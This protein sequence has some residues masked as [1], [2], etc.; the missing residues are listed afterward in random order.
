MV[1]FS[2]D[3]V[4]QVTIVDAFREPVWDRLQSVCLL[5]DAGAD[6]PQPTPVCGER[7][8][9]VRSRR[10]QLLDADWA[11]YV[12]P[13]GRAHGIIGGVLEL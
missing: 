5:S 12:R 2:P 7:G 1:Q 8:D 6:R 13:R 11:R 3:G 4:Y 10:R 9:S